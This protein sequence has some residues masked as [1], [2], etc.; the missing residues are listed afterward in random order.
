M[1]GTLTAL[2]ERFSAEHPELRD[3]SGAHDRCVPVSEAFAALLV[4]HGVVAEVVDGVRFGEVPE[5]PGERLMLGGHYAVAVTTDG[6]KTVCDWTAR[7]FDPNAPVPLVKP[8]AVWRET[9]QRLSFSGGE[10]Q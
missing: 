4:E 10:Q 8:L 5:F 6:G 1:V 7:Q 2:V 9:W 3:P